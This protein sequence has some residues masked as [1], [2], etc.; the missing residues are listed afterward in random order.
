MILIS[1]QQKW[2]QQYFFFNFKKMKSIQFE[3]KDV[4]NEIPGI[5]CFQ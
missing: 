5:I 2:R 1:K 4:K 3:T